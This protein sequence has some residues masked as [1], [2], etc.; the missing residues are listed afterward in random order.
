MDL[1]TSI[2]LLRGINVSGQKKIKMAD[3]KNRF[4]EL[5]FHNVRT[6]IQSGNVLFDHPSLGAREL[7]KRIEEKIARDYG[8]EVPAMVLVPSDL[9]YVLHNNPFLNG[10]KE[11]PKRLYVTFL[12]EVPPSEN[13]KGLEG[14]DYHPEEYVLDGRFI[15]FFS[16]LGYGRA[17]MNNNFFEQKLKVKATTRNWKTINVLWEMANDR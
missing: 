6:Y 5:D 14:L 17:R 12:A 2:A 8:F 13:V 7:E 15:F 1:I 4:E 16:P 10:R 11:D 9:E 3:L